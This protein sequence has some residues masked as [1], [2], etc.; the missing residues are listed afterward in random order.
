MTA[1]IVYPISTPLDE[2]VAEHG[3]DSLSYAEIAGVPHWVVVEQ[4]HRHTHSGQTL[5]HAHPHD[6]PHGY[7]GHNEDPAPH[8][9]S[10]DTGTYEKEI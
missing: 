7:F 8:T 1:A 5:V 4:P 6:E 2:I 9:P 3:P 10:A